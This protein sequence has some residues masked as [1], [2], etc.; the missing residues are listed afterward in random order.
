VSGNQRRWK[1]SPRFDDDATP[2]AE[3]RPAWSTRTDE[4]QRESG[5]VVGWNTGNHYGFVRRR[6]DARGT[7]VFLHAAAL[8]PDMTYPLPIGTRL[9][10]VVVHTA[11]G[12][13]AEEARLERIAG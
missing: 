6:G 9:S 7:D 13:R 5:I 3:T 1:P 2:Y 8:P 12:L 11:K 10:F 4:R